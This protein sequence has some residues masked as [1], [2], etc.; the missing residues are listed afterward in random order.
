MLVC[1]TESSDLEE[2]F[3]ICL[4]TSYHTPIRASTAASHCSQSEILHAGRVRQCVSLMFDPTDFNV[5]T[6]K[7][8][9]HLT[10]FLNHSWWHDCAQSPVGRR[11][12]IYSCRPNEMWNFKESFLHRDSASRWTSNSRNSEYAKCEKQL[13]WRLNST[14][15]NSV[16]LLHAC[17]WT[18]EQLDCWI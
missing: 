5:S 10:A 4:Y 7:I 18:A 15:L 13:V 11:F 16:L 9:V 17:S 12:I 6:P 1:T 8:G 3:T 2:F 14:Q